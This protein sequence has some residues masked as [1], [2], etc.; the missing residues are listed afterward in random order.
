M[1]TL[2]QTIRVWDIVDILAI[3]YLLYRVLIVMRR[4][5]PGSVINGIIILLAV[6]YVSNLFNLKVMKFILNQTL[7]MGVIVLVVLF[8]PEL[9]KLFE[10]M[11]SRRSGSLFRRRVKN[12]DFEVML[13]HVVAACE[14]MAKSKT[15]ALIV[16]EREIGL[17][18][19]GATGTQLDAQITSELLQ[20][21]FYH[22][23]P[24]HDG[25]LLIRDARI[26]S[27]ACMLPLTNNA[28][29]ASGLGMRHRAAVGISERSDAVA[30]IVSEQTGFI[31]VAVDGMLKRR[32]N[33]ET[34]ETM[35]RSELTQSSAVS[36]ARAK[37]KTGRTKAKTARKQKVDKR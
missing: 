10:H 35:L 11:G 16:F 26:T 29:L 37:R 4:T 18:D 17:N 12:E 36:R 33:R 23:S 34:F 19:Y 2:N 7:Q 22:N 5:S 27:A 25:A 1:T 9:R 32:L 3:A 15:G 13:S 28:N 8:Q 30:V 31:S 14:I 6:A 24:L 21:I 20:N